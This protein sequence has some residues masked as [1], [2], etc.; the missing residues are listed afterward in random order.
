MCLYVLF[1]SATSLSPVFL[2]QGIF[3]CLYGTLSHCKSTAGY[4]VTDVSRFAYKSIRIHRASVDSH[5]SKLFHLQFES[6]TLK[7]IRI[8]NLS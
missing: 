8:H 2:E 1:H 5:T 7:S 3:M 6:P 4:V